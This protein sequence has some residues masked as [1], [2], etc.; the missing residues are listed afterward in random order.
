MNEVLV[1]EGFR[2]EFQRHLQQ[3]VQEGWELRT[4]TSVVMPAGGCEGIPG[5]MHSAVMLKPEPSTDI[6][7]RPRDWRG[8]LMPWDD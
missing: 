7:T 1:I 6:D 4:H 8:N 3:A 2:Q 5:V